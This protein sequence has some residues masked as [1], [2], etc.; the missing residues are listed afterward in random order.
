VKNTQQRKGLSNVQIV[1]TTLKEQIKQNLVFLMSL[2]KNRSITVN[3]IYRVIISNIMW[4]E[5]GRTFLLKRVDGEFSKE[6]NWIARELK[7]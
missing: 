1:Y 5:D 3:L 6:M 7:N 4:W 2:K